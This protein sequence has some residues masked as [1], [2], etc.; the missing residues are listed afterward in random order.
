MLQ[1]H[2]KEHTKCK[3]PDS[4]SRNTLFGQLLTRNKSLENIQESSRFRLIFKKAK[5]HAMMSYQH[6]KT[7]LLTSC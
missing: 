5:R 1:Q 2:S 6:V 7:S 4:A 3:P